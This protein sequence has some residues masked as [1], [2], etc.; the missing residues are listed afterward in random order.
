MDD[1]APDGS[2]RFGAVD[3]LLWAV[4]RDPLL[5]SVVTGISV[6]DTEISPAALK[7]RLERTTR[8]VPRMR[9]RV[10]SDTI[11]PSPP[12]WELDPDFDLANHLEVVQCPTGGGMRELLGL[13]SRFVAEPL[14]TE[15]PLFRYLLVQRFEGDQSALI[16]KAHHAMADGLGTLAIQA[17]LFDSEPDTD[18]PIDLPPVTV[19]DERPTAIQPGSAIEDQVRSG[20]SAL[21][22]HRKDGHRRGDRSDRRVRPRR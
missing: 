21:R 10:V 1:P 4:D 18:D 9:Q 11:W 19:V 22:E 5:A 14:D 2:P 16:M 6:F 13:A 20:L 7:A 17:E 8:V 15:R 12:R 3:A